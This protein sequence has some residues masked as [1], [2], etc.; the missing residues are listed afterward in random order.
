MATV[1]VTRLP[2]SGSTDGRPIVIGSA[3]LVTVHTA[4]AGTDDIDEV[5]IYASSPATSP[6]SV[7]FLE[8]YYGGATPYDVVGTL[9]YGFQNKLVIP[10]AV[11]RNSLVVKAKVQAGPDVHVFGYVNRL[12][13]E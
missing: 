8:V 9:I 12:V 2:L 4:V 7:T 5:W 13:A 11:L 3:S 6:T 10:G 1:S